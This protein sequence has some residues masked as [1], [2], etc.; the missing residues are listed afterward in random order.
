AAPAAAAPARPVPA[1]GAARALQQQGVR[2]RRDVD[3]V[4]LLRRDSAYALH[5]LRRIAILAAILITT[6]IVL[7]VVLR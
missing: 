3:V 6:L 5:E 2:K 7:G 1:V 4:E